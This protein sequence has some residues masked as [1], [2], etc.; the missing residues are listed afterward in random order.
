MRVSGSRLT[1]FGDKTM[2]GNNEE[3]EMTVCSANMSCDWAYGA[4]WEELN[5]HREHPAKP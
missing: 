1:N 4:K 2:I 5:K 3:A